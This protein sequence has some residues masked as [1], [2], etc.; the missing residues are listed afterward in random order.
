MRTIPEQQNAMLRTALLLQFVPGGIM[1]GA[2]VALLIQHAT[3][4]AP[5]VAL[6]IGWALW[7]IGS[8]TTLTL[9]A[10]S[11]S[12]LQQR[13]ARA[14]GVAVSDPAALASWTPAAAVLSRL[15]PA[16]KR[17]EFRTALYTA[18]VPGRGPLPVA[19]RL[20]ADS[21]PQKLSGAVLRLDPQDPAVAAIDPFAT[22]VE[23]SAAAGD[24]ALAT[25]TRAELGLS[26]P[27]GVWLPW[28]AVGLGVAALTAL[29]ILLIG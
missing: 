4:A 7:M 29:L 1:L 18:N 5:L 17:A 25:L 11:E 8:I 24:P 28:L 13:L 20:A 21:A 27:I 2:F 12:G 3:H 26:R 19:V 10:R 9:M 14:T 6:L 16:R 22:A 15:L 23:H